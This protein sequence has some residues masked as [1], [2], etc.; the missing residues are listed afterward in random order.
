MNEIYCKDLRGAKDLIDALLEEGY[1]ILISL[2]DEI[3]TIKYFAPL[4]QLVE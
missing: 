4:T 3:Y 1:G 2:K